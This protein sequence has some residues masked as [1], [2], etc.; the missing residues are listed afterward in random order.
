M[1]IVVAHTPELEKI[2]KE[3]THHAFVDLYAKSS[4]CGVLVP[5]ED[6]ADFEKICNDQS[7]AEQKL[8]EATQP[9]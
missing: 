8:Y 3:H 7:Y 9:F 1:K 2:I 6:E 4:Y 5:C